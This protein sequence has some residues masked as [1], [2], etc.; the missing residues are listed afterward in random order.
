MSKH[1]TTATWD[2]APH[3]S[4]EAK[5][6]LMSE[7]P[8]HLRDARTKG[9]PSLGAGAI[10][11]IPESEIVCDPFEM[12]EFWPRCFGMDVGWNRTAAVWGAWDRES[13]VVYLYSEYYRGQA[14]PSIHADAVRTR[15][16]WIP[17]AID[18]ASRGRGQ[19]DGRNLLQC[20]MDLGLDLTRAE[21]AVEAGLYACW[22]R[23][24][25][26]RL[27]I[28]STLRNWLAEYRKYR[29]D[30]DGKV[31]KED[32]HLMDAMRYLVMTGLD[33]AKVNEATFEDWDIDDDRN[34]I[35]GY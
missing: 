23:M 16:G 12:P 20:Y 9:I 17:G 30:E 25:A 27:K 8:P 15:G 2:D 29:R 18:P 22:Q 21:N 32:D 6:E 5:A 11:P 14:E 10:Y 24:S 3:L 35:S 26:G 34:T 1:V 31:V 33:I 28:F 4:D 19:V 7:I 13:G